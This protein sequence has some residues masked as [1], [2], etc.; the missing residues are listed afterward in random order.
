MD[1]NS[2][3]LYSN[4]SAAYLNLRNYQLALAD[5]KKALQIAPSFTKAY[6]RAC[7]ACL[8][9]GFYKEA[10]ELITSGLDLVEDPEKL[11]NRLEEIAP[12]KEQGM[13]QLVELFGSELAQGTDGKRVQTSQVLSDVKKVLI[14]FSANWLLN[15]LPLS[16]LCMCVCVPAV[17]LCL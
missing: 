11:R 13:K 4:R 3:I 1:A 5:A 16:Y 12:A 14:Y 7:T 6:I 17:R 10:Q 2:H 9:I 8:A 15:L